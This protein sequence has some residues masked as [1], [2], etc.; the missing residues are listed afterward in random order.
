MV[1]VARSWDTAVELMGDTGIWRPELPV[2][3]LVMVLA[4]ETVARKRLPTATFGACLRKR[5]ASIMFITLV[6]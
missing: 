2:M 3:P 1:N 6:L 4:L 5:A